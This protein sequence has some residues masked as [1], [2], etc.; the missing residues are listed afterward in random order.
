MSFQFFTSS[1]N[2]SITAPGPGGDRTRPREAD[3]P[4]RDY[5][6]DRERSAGGRRGGKLLRIAAGAVDPSRRHRVRP[7]APQQPG[8][9]SK[10][11][12]WQA[13]R[14]TVLVRGRRRRAARG[15]PGGAVRP[16]VRPGAREAGAALCRPGHPAREDR[17]RGQVHGRADHTIE[18]A[19]AALKLQRGPAAASPAQ[20]TPVKA[21]APPGTELQAPALTPPKEPVAAGVPAA[22]LLSAAAAS[23]P[24]TVAHVL[25]GASLRAAMM[26]FLTKTAESNGDVG[27]SR[28]DVCV[29]FKTSSEV[30]VNGLLAEMVADGDAFTT[31]D[32]NHFTAV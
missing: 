18:A 11:R 32:D 10:R 16:H 21:Q 15:R 25:S 12:H 28:S 4:A 26:E 9:C 13:P 5:S 2:G 17:G 20:A 23:P 31:I 6:L 19:H 14:P 7:E 27:C 30:E 29:H 22:G 1:Q 8:P 24:A 3:K